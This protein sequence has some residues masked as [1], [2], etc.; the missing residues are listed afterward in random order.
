MQ[1]LTIQQ[2]QA[3][4]RDNN[5]ECADRRV[6]KN[7]EAAIEA[8]QAQQ[9]II[10][11]AVAMASETIVATAQ[12]SEPIAEKASEQIETTVLAIGAL[13]VAALT[14]E[15]AIKAYRAILRAVAIAIVFALLMAMKAGKWAWE[16]RDRTAVYCWIQD[17]GESKAYWRIKTEV[18]R[19]QWVAGRWFDD[20]IVQRDRL[21]Q[22]LL[23]R[24]EMILTRIGLGGSTIEIQ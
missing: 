2:L 15:T 5:L 20:R 9:E 8:F 4:V 22:V 21:V 1:L 13:V 14:S 10:V 12:E 24:M 17:A 18:E 23:D 16:N 19:S 7:L 11:E 6:R 3:I